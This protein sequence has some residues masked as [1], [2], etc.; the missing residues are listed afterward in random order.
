M[1]GISWLYWNSVLNWKSQ[2]TSRTR[3]RGAGLHA[4]VLGRFLPI[5]RTPRCAPYYWVVRNSE[6]GIVDRGRQAGRGSLF[7]ILQDQTLL[8]RYNYLTTGI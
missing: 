3:A 8:V 1:D 5:L 7:V 2:A 4:R 6:A